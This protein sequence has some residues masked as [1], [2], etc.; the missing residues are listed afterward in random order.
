[1]SK[2]PEICLYCDGD[3]NSDAGGPCGFC[4]GGKP[5]DTQE[6]WDNSWGKVQNDALEFMLALSEENQDK[7]ISLLEL[8]RKEK[9]ET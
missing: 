8:V 5:L 7:I 6:D 2:A 3:G 9:N 4:V 1:M